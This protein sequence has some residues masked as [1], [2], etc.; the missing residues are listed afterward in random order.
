MHLRRAATSGQTFCTYL[1][2][3]FIAKRG[4]QHA[5]IPET[6]GLFAVSDFVLTLSDG[7]MFTILCMIDREAHQ[8]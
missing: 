5:D 1:A 8:K 6:N 7:L 2:K 3:Q 4:F